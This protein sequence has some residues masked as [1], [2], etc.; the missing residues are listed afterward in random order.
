MVPKSMHRTHTHTVIA[1]MHALLHRSSVQGLPATMRESSLGCGIR[2]QSL[3]CV[4][5][6]GCGSL[7]PCL[8]YLPPACDDTMCNRWRVRMVGLRTAQPVNTQPL[9]HLICCQQYNR[10]LVMIAKER[11]ICAHL[12]LVRHDYI[13]GLVGGRPTRGTDV[14]QLAPHKV[15][16]ISST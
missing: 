9:R 14:P 16:C 4:S 15:K 6:L 10:Q 13:D 5:H 12:H 1:V 2:L 3:P 7:G 11:V 8:M